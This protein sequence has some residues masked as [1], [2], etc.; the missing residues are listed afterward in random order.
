MGLLDDINGNV[1]EEKKLDSKINKTLDKKISDLLLIFEKWLDSYKD[2]KGRKNFEQAFFYL[3]QKETCQKTI[4]E[5]CMNMNKLNN[6]PKYGASGVFISAMIQNSF[7]QGHNNFTINAYHDTLFG[8]LPS[9]LKGNVHNYIKVKIK[10]N[11][12]NYCIS[13]LN[14]CDITFNG[15]SGSNIGYNSFKTRFR[16]KNMKTLNQARKVSMPCSSFYLIDD[17][18]KQTQIT[19]QL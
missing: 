9:H 4:D 16:S 19:Y 17:N 14:C 1:E 3:Y 11:I 13:Y 2:F 7:I 6:H 5:F 12:G 8:G 18:S 15:Q 10:G